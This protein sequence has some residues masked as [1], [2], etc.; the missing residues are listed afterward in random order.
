VKYI[1]QKLRALD[2]YIFFQIIMDACSLR[3]PSC[4][5]QTVAYTWGKHDG[6]GKRETDLLI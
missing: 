4:A 6:V 5:V 2:E 3:W 1:G